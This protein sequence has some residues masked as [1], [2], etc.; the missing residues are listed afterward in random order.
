MIFYLFTCK[1]YVRRLLKQIGKSDSLP[2]GHSHHIMKED[3]RCLVYG[4]DAKSRSEEKPQ[5]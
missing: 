5:R 1:N 3:F 2:H 4:L